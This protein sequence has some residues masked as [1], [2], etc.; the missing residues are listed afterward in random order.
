MPKLETSRL[1]LRA[2]KRSDLEDIFEYSSNAQTSKYLMW[3]PHKSKEYTKDLIELILSKYKE[4]EYN[5]WAIVYKPT[6]KMIGTCGF[7][8]I[9]EQNSLVEVGYVINPSFWGMGFATEAVEKVIDFA[10][11][12]MDVNRI[13]CKFMFG[14]DASLAVMKK[15]GMK[16]EGYQR[17]AIFIKGKFHTIGVAS[18]LKREYNLK[19]K[20]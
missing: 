5:D 1:I 9:D 15:V 4:G 14:N 20:Y 17:D 11:S 10:F 12:E 18:I 6:G 3:T 13:E 8:R 2:I 16:L 7:T 19:D